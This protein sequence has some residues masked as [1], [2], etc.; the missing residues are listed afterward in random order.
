MEAAIAMLVVTGFLALGGWSVWYNDRHPINR[1]ETGA[2]REGA[3]GRYPYQTPQQASADRRRAGVDRLAERVER[4]ERRLDIC[5]AE[6]D[7]R[8]STDEE[9]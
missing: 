3:A 8:T 2:A 5:A 1:N 6:A 9:G 7:R 4:I